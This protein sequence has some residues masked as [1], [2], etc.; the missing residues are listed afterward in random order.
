MVL[1]DVAAPSNKPI[2]K[3]V[4]SVAP[5]LQGQPALVRFW[6]QSCLVA[7]TSDGSKFPRAPSRTLLS[8]SCKV[9]S[10][11]ARATLAFASFVAIATRANVEKYNLT[12]PYVVATLTRWFPDRSPRTFVVLS[13]SFSG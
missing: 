10:A 7:M 6:C 2:P 8:P 13:T 3:W 5:H 12:R 4:Y 1:I 9:A 11:S